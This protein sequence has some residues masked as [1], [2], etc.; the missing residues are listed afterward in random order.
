MIKTQLIDSILTS[1][2][3]TT[4]YENK[5]ETNLF[6]KSKH[7]SNLESNF[8][9]TVIDSNSN[10][11]KQT[12]VLLYS[13]KD[14]I[15]LLKT[16]GNKTMIAFNTGD[17]KEAISKYSVYQIPF[18]LKSHLKS[19]HNIELSN[20]EFFQ[21]KTDFLRINLEGHLILK[22]RLRKFGD[23]Q[24]FFKTLLKTNQ[25][26]TIRDHINKF[27]KSLEEIYDEN[28]FNNNYDITIQTENI[29]KEII[30]KYNLEV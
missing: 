15:G 29:N 25:Q 19:K 20:K 17:Y 14:L 9:K 18:L 10:P 30:K 23:N 28:L 13:N 1:K 8:Y 11:L 24:K 26:L 4:I 27:Y 2:Q 16:T 7:C 22:E 5:E 21:K 6:I 3:I 12:G